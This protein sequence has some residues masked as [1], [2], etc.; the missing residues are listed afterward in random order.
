MKTIKLGNKEIGTGCPTYVIAEIGFNHGGYIDLAAQM[1]EKAA[2]T[3]VDA[4]KFQTFKA[5]DLVCEDAEHFK[6][7]ESCELS[8]DDHEKLIAIAKDND[9]A[10]LSTPFSNQSVDMLEKVNVSGYKVA[11]MDINNLPF[12]KYIASFGKPMI[13]STGMATI[14]EILEAINSVRDAGNGKIVLLHCISK[15]PVDAKEAN[16]RNISYFK[17]IFGLPVGYSDHGVENITSYVAVSLG[18][19]LIEKHFTVDKT[20]PGPDHK[21]SADPQ[22]MIQL[23][24]GIRAIEESMG[25]RFNTIERPDKKEA[26]MFRRSLHSKVDIPKGTVINARM[27]K[28]VRPQ[29]GLAPKYYNVVISRTAKVDIPKDTPISFDVI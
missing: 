26:T 9:V 6:V 23:V 11:S 13:I 12:L 25:K 19:C 27:L 8:A 28:C 3:G 29:N 17:E 1:I 16:L 10:F 21:I 4:V 7:I 5:S 2:E 14:A 15:Y 20:M 22:E 24:Q 18:A